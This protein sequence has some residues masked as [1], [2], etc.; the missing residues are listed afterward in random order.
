M[1]R[2]FWATALTLGFFCGLAIDGA[3]LAAQKTTITGVPQQRLVRKPPT[4]TALT[5]SECTSLGGT[6]NDD[7]A[8]CTAAGQFTCK[9]VT[10]DAAGATHVHTPCIDNK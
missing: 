7:S 6:V 9:T 3:A 1:T 2:K 4:F 5:V 10:I 8:I